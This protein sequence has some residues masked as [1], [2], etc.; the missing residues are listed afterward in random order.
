MQLASVGFKDTKHEDRVKIIEA[1]M[2]EHS[3][4]ADDGNI[5]AVWSDPH[6]N[7]QA[8]QLTTLD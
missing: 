5:D 4:H 6:P 1:F 7:W 2:E 8:T 3:G